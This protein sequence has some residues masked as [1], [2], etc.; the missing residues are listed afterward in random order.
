M[1][2]CFKSCLCIWIICKFKIWKMATKSK[3][4]LFE[5]EA[6]R[7]SKSI[8]FWNCCHD[9]YVWIRVVYEI[10]IRD[11]HQ[12]ENYQKGY[13][14]MYHTCVNKELTMKNCHLF[15]TVIE[16]IRDCHLR[17]IRDWHYW[18]GLG[19]VVTKLSLGIVNS[20]LSCQFYSSSWGWKAFSVL[21]FYYPNKIF[22]KVGL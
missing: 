21:L 20:C 2:N 13:H 22:S 7:K 8:P 18:F 6:T 15:G 5:T 19:S 3:P 16:I 17:D 4:D 14:I 12:I 10:A 1:S 11:C 9:I